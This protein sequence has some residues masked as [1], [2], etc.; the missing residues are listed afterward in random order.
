MAGEKD[1]PQF[2]KI[3]G[4]LKVLILKIQKAGSVINTNILLQDVSDDM[5]KVILYNHSEK[6]AILFGLIRT[7]PG[8]V[9]RI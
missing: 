7:K 5:K 1:H 8:T 3:E 6:M 4:M 9:I 2:F